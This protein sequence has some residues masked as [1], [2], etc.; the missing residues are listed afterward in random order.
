MGVRVVFFDLVGTLIRPRQSIGMQY[1]SHAR[2]HG[3]AEADADRLDAAF[4]EAMRRAPPMTIPRGTLGDVAAEERRW[5]REL[6]LSVVASAG[7][8]RALA[9]PTFDAF[10]VDLFEHFATDAAWETYPDVPPALGRLQ[11][12]GIG[13]GLITNYDTRVYRVVDSVGIGRFFDSVTIPADAGVAKPSPGIF[14]AGLAA[15]G[16]EAAAAAYVGDSLEDDYDG[17]SAVGMTAILLDRR[18][19]HGGKGLRRIV[20]LDDLS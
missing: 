5:W 18:G 7:L 12:A 9:G 2:R 3:A 14:H 4:S 11:S 8:S 20:S 19:R 16:A 10:F 17:A 13:V 6:V 1:A 15:H